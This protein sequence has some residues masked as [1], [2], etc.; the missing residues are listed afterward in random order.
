MNG[1]ELICGLIYFIASPS[2]Q[3]SQNTFTEIFI[4]RFPSVTLKKRALKMWRLKLYETLSIYRAFQNWGWCNSY[5]D[6]NADNKTSRFVTF[7]MPSLKI[8]TKKTDRKEANSKYSLN[9]SSKAFLSV[10]VQFPKV[11]QHFHDSGHVST[12]N[13]L[14]PMLIKRKRG[15][16]KKRK[17]LQ[18]KK[19]KH[20]CNCDEIFSKS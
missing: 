9:S 20:Q 7:L 6:V 15:K 16:K 3:L 19:R 18:K 11:H 17:K 14:A 4:H 5:D 10:V 12:S 1:A 8:T 2:L 13:S